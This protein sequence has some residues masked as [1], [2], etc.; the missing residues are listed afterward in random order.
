MLCLLFTVFRSLY[1]VYKSLET[2]LMI[3]LTG[4]DT[5]RDAILPA[6]SGFPYFSSVQCENEIKF[7]FFK[8]VIL[9]VDPLFIYQL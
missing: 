4:P 1:N 8:I 3:Y 2:K 5:S 7:S 9:R 6:F